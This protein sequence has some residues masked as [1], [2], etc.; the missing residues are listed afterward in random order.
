MAY[1][2]SSHYIGDCYGDH[3]KLFT[4]D[5]INKRIIS[6]SDPLTTFVLAPS[7]IGYG[8]L[9]NTKELAKFTVPSNSQQVH[10]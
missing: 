4:D 10:I 2:I 5:V 9:A 7:S 6:L 8:L 3:T 1:L